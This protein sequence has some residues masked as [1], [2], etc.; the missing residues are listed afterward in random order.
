M[1]SQVTFWK[2]SAGNCLSGVMFLL[3][4]MFGVAS[5][6]WEM[7]DRAVVGGFASLMFSLLLFCKCLC[8][9]CKERNL[10]AAETAAEAGR[11][12]TVLKQQCVDKATSASR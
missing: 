1:R 11:E 7:S 2:S 4:G 9:L 5:G 6:I 12:F 3:L 10:I 8:C